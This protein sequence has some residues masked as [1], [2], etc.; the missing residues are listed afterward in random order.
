MLLKSSQHHSGTSA[1]RRGRRV[2]C[3]LRKTISRRGR[4]SCPSAACF[5][6][7]RSRYS[8]FRRACC[9]SSKCSIARSAC[10]HT[11]R[12]KALGTRCA[13]CCPTSA[14]DPSTCSAS[15]RCSRICAGSAKSAVSFGP[16]CS[17]CHAEP[18]S[19][20]SDEACG[21]HPATPI[22]CNAS[23]SPDIRT[24]ARACSSARPT[25]TPGFSRQFWR[26]RP[27]A[28]VLAWPATAGSARSGPACG[29]R[30]CA[31]RRSASTSSF[32]FRQSRSAS[33]WQSRSHAYWQSWS[34]AFRRSPQRPASRPA[35]APRSTYASAA[36]KRRWTR[37]SLF[38]ASY[39]TRWSKWTRRSAKSSLRPASWGGS[40]RCASRFT[41]TRPGW[42]GRHASR[43]S[44][45]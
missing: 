42:P 15:C 3:G 2:R 5:A 38:S 21:S 11:G 10:T 23:E 6:A 7:S 12:C 19:S 1:S 39:R 4:K 24:Q 34:F 31:T 44:S 18:C 36:R 26:C 27:A 35:H 33:H 28:P 14:V 20:G 29:W 9:C 13:G 41:S 32:A 37:S 40:V 22:G 25:V 45:G 30:F 17:S 16:S 8:A 43:A